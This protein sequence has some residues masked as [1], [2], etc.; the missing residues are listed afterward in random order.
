MVGKT[1]LTEDSLPPCGQLWASALHAVSL[2]RLPL[3]EPITHKRCVM[4]I[5]RFEDS[6]ICDGLCFDQSVIL[7][8]QGWHSA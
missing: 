7:T 5:S 6:S 3:A 1:A 2:C 4:G 8:V